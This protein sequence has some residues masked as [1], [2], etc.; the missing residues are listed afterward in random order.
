MKKRTKYQCEFCYTEYADEKEA[1][2]CE[3]SHKKIVCIADQR[4]I[5]KNNDCTGYPIC[6]VVKMNDGKLIKYRRG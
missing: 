4:Y 1:K 2:A 3:D 6:I 5:P